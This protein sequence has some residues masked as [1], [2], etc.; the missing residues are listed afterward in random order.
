MVLPITAQV[1]VAV[2]IL[3]LTAWACLEL[4]KEK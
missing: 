1:V 2:V 4:I 3:L